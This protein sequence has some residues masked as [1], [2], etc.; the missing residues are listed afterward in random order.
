MP[1]YIDVQRLL[2]Q[3]GLLNL[4][5]FFFHHMRFLTFFFFL[6]WKV[7]HFP[8]L[9]FTLVGAMASVTFVILGLKSSTKSLTENPERGGVEE[10]AALNMSLVFSV[11]KR[12]EI[13]SVWSFVHTDIA[14]S[15]KT[16]EWSESNIR[17]QN[18]L[19][20]CCVKGWETWMLRSPRLTHNQNQC[21]QQLN[22]KTACAKEVNVPKNICS[23]LSKSLN[24]I[25]TP[26]P[27][28]CILAHLWE[29]GWLELN[30]LKSVFD[31]K[32]IYLE[33]FLPGTWCLAQQDLVGQNQLCTFLQPVVAEKELELNLI[34]WQI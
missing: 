30:E 23:H 22:K 5:I 20:V 19:Y 15:K 27:V 28:L 18:L 21:R 10:K 16:Q 2:A 25:L 34:N 33:F 9:T 32:I 1:L 12:F 6:F 11:M 7:W 17:H 4:E 3:R 8:L 26:L 13:I 29:F 31:D 24:R 14:P